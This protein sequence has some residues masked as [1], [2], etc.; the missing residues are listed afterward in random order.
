M[1]RS[2]RGCSIGCGCVRAARSC[3]QPILRLSHHY[4]S[5]RNLVLYH[6]FV[7]TNVPK[8]VMVV[9]STTTSPWNI[10]V[11][12]AFTRLSHTTRLQPPQSVIAGHC[13]GSDAVV[14]AA[15]GNAAPVKSTCLRLRS[16]R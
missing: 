14:A 11:R 7:R 8:M 5:S 1:L 4:G 3:T 16:I 2:A 15:I 9:C 6:S 12:K 10:F 13:D